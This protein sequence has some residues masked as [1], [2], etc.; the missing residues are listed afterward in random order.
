MLLKGRES[1]QELS[2]S[3]KVGEHRAHLTRKLGNGE[4]RKWGLRIL[5][6]PSQF[7]KR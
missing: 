1:T 6:I 4:V 3:P 5:A 7:L 2:T